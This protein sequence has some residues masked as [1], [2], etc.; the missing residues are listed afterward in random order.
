MSVSL[1]MDV[2]V[3]FAITDQLRVAAVDVV[4]AQDDGARRFSDQDLLDRATQLGR[5]LVTQDADLLVEGSLRQRT[6]RSFEGIIY[7]PQARVS[8][9]N[10]VADL[11]LI[12][13]LT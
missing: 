1:Y 12:A 9:G 5:I 7:T 6:G 8:I 3:P 2:S 10:C 4:T 11:G 13:K